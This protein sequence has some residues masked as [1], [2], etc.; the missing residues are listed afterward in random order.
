MDSFYCQV[1]I[2]AS[3]L[4]NFTVLMTICVPVHC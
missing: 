4:Y 2:I 3:K 1:V